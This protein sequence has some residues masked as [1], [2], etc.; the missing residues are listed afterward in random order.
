MNFQISLKSPEYISKIVTLFINIYL[1][2][3]ML[4]YSYD[5]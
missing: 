2:V 4:L 1:L 5:S 3:G